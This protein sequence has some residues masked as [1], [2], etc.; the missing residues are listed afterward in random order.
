MPLHA[1]SAG[2][3]SIAAEIP[4]VFT[5]RMAESSVLAPLCRTPS[6]QAPSLLP[7]THSWA[8]L[9]VPQFPCLGKKSNAEH[10]GE[11]LEVTA[12]SPW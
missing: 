9:P 7:H 12:E 6:Q 4:A 2:A 3:R 5:F 8:A 11:P 10:L 1:G